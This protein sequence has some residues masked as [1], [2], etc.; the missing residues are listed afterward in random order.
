MKVKSNFLFMNHM[1]YKYIFL[2]FLTISISIGC[3]HRK[4]AK[5]SKEYL[6]SQIINLISSSTKE[7]YDS[8]IILPGTGCTGCIT[9][10]EDF[11][12]ENYKNSDFLFVLTNITSVKTMNHK[13][14]DDLTQ[15]AN[16]YLDFEN[17]FSRYESSIYPVS[18][19]IDCD[20]L[21]VKKI[22]FLG[23]DQNI[24]E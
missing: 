24:F 12:I 14:K 9:K 7:C 15:V 6:E 17:V 1:N 10:I 22:D 19:V 3:S 21:E 18:I 4:E 20:K 8:I 5:E 16:V 13:V 23:P 11:F 2:L